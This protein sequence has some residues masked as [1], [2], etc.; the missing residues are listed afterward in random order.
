MD[1]KLMKAKLKQ[2]LGSSAFRQYTAG[3]KSNRQAQI[4][5]A[6]ENWPTAKAR[7]ERLLRNVGLIEVAHEIPHLARHMKKVLLCLV[8]DE[9]IPDH[10]K[11]I[12][13][14]ALRDAG[15]ETITLFDLV[16]SDIKLG[17]L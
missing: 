8:R 6:L 1:I 5:E 14:D 4:D 7:R 15:D 17:N 10:I 3:Q 16:A 12:I 13:R 9:P 2:E 11:T